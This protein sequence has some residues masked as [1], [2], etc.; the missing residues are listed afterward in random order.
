MI[1]LSP[2][3]YVVV[4]PIAEGHKVRAEI[5][6]VLYPMQIKSLKEQGEW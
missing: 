2:G 6:Y 1:L 3:D 5:V 4:E